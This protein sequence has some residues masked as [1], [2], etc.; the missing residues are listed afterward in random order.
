MPSLKKQTAGWLL[1]T[2]ERERRAE[3][4]E[5]IS[6]EAPGGPPGDPDD[7]HTTVACVILHTLRHTVERN[8]QI[9]KQ[10]KL[11]WA[12]LSFPDLIIAAPII[13]VIFIIVLSIYGVCFHHSNNVT[14]EF[15]C[16]E[17]EGGGGITGCMEE[18]AGDEGVLLP[19]SMIFILCEGS[20]NN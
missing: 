1:E 18:A 15:P 9:Q 16:R 14:L 19:G 11:Q 3:T 12:S 20:H 6:E 2:C 5:R 13:A 8:S 10:S 17:R 7:Y 4:G